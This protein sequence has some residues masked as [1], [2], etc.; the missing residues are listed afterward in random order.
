MN[1]ERLRSEIVEIARRLYARGLIAANEGNLSARDDDSVYITPAGVCKGFLTSDL[2]VTTD[3]NGRP[4][5]SARPSTEIP[6]HLAIYRARPDVRA[7]VHAHPPVATGFAVAAIPLDR[8]VLAEAVVVLGPVPLIP[9]AKPATDEL[10]RDV[11][12]AVAAA[13]AL[14]MANHGALTL[15]ETVTKAWERMETLEQL[16]RVSLVAR[17]LGGETTVPPEG[18]A[19]LLGHG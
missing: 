12:A 16:A 17:L 19:R 2:I 10:A 6:M 9:F 3:L 1:P 13:D 18:V 7:I 14:L 4:R 11:A 5:G 15:G 8:P